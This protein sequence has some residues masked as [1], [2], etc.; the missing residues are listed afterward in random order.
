MHQLANDNTLSTY[1]KK[2]LRLTIFELRFLPLRRFIRSILPRL[3]HG[4]L[5]IVRAPVPKEYAFVSKWLRGKFS[6]N[7]IMLTSEKLNRSA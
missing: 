5:N 6:L 4:N 1:K 3:T 2:Y 7:R